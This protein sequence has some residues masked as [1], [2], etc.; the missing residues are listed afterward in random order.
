MRDLGGHLCCP[1]LPSPQAFA[2]YLDR[3]E[4]LA[5]SYAPGCGRSIHVVGTNGGT[6]PCGALLTQFGKTNPYF[7]PACE[8]KL[9]IQNL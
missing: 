7:C 5:A 4:V 3:Q 9:Q 6:M 8:Q 2:A 1:E